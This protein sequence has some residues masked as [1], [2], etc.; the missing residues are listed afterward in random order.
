M[1]N[2]GNGEVAKLEKSEVSEVHTVS[3]L[4]VILVHFP[5][6]HICRV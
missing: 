1:V 3:R 2:G 6:K 4:T 5:T